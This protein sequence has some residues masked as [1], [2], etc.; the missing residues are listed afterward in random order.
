MQDLFNKNKN[1]NFERN[2]AC[3]SITVVPDTAFLDIRRFADSSKRFLTNPDFIDKKYEL[4]L[5]SAVPIRMQYDLWIWNFDPL[6]VK[7]FFEIFI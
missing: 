5:C 2:A 4:F 6:P 7:S 1:D 3:N